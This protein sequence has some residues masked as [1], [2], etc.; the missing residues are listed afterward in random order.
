MKILKPV[1]L[2]LTLL[3]CPVFAGVSLKGTGSILAAP[4]YSQWIEEYSQGKPDVRN[5]Y[6]AEKV[7]TGGEASPGSWFGLA[8]TDRPLTNLEQQKTLSTQILR[9]GGFGSGGFITYNTAVPT[10]LKLTPGSNRH[11]FLGSI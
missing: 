6:E 1:S 2:S 5:R 7:P 4:L 3:A 9:R 11:I 8:A 10:G